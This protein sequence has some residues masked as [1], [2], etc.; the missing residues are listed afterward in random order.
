LKEYGIYLTFLKRRCYIIDKELFGNICFIRLGFSKPEA[1]D[2][3]QEN[4]ISLTPPTCVHVMQSCMLTVN[5][6]NPFIVI[7]HI[8]NPFI[9]RSAVTGGYLRDEF[10][11]EASYSTMMERW[12]QEKLRAVSVVIIVFLNDD[13]TATDIFFFFYVEN[14]SISELI[15]KGRWV[16]P[17]FRQMQQH[18]C[19][20]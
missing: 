6:D 8:Y 17:L 9:P 12:A 10:D 13:E 5:Y 1:V 14:L 19:S 7:F 15:F 11:R 4:S 20:S 3:S 16:R 2:K 18:C